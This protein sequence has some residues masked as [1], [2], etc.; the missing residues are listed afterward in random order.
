LNDTLYA[1]GDSGA[2]ESDDDSDSDYN[3]DAGGN[4]ESN[5]SDRDYD[6]D[7]GGYRES[8]D[9]ISDKFYETVQDEEDDS[10]ES[11]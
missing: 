2:E 1:G 7:A 8:N 11:K 4:I 10:V 5:D 3:P 6:P 9:I